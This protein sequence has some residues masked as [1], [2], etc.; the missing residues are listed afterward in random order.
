MPTVTT[1]VGALLGLLGIEGY[2][3]SGRASKTAL[4]PAGFGAALIALGLAGR[5]EGARHHTMHTAVA[6]GMLGVLGSARG[7]P[8]ALRLARGDEVARPTAVA[9]QAAM[10]TICAGYLGLSM[11]SFVTTRHACV[12]LSS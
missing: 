8:A 2:A 11:C 12:T 1:L 9:A 5:D 6:V 3:G 7:L 4:I 10:F